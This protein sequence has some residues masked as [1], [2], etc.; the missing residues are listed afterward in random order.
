MRK[1]F[2]LLLLAVAGLAIFWVIGSRESWA[3]E[4]TGADPMYRSGRA[5]I[6]KAPALEGAPWPSRIDN[7]GPQP[8][9]HGAERGVIHTF[10]AAQFVG[11]A[12]DV[13]S[14]YGSVP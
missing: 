13:C 7:R 3:P 10:E 9:G 1:R 11:G 6:C 12:I 4:L 5:S 2:V 8:L 14:E